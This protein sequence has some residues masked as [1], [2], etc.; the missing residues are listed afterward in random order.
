MIEFFDIILFATIFSKM[1]DGKDSGKLLF[2]SLFSGSG[3]T[4]SEDDTSMTFSTTGGPTVVVVT[5]LGKVVVTTGRDL[6]G[7]TVVVVG[8]ETPLAPST[9]SVVVVGAR[10]ATE[11]WP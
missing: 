9:G 11:T 1:G 4:I 10:V 7:A 6:F 2:K 5:I 3:F 8:T